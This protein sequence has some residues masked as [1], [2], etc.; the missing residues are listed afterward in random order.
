MTSLTRQ[1]LVGSRLLLGITKLL[2]SL[3]SRQSHFTKM[4]LRCGVTL[5]GTANACVSEAQS[6]SVTFRTL[7]LPPPFWG[8]TA[9]SFPSWL[10]WNM[11]CISSRFHTGQAVEVHLFV[12]QQ[13]TCDFQRD[14][15]P[16]VVY[17]MVGPLSCD[18]RYLAIT[19]QEVSVTTDNRILGSAA[20]P[21]G[22]SRGG[23]AHWAP[24][25]ANRVRGSRI[26]LRTSDLRTT[27]L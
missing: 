1:C 13:S 5:P 24:S 6:V 10:N 12:C 4:K 19:N 18:D 9:L 14:S 7:S 26:G 3:L 23:H 25:T 2:W 17:A 22:L 11:S 27:T 21:S 15:A 8:K 20:R 16:D